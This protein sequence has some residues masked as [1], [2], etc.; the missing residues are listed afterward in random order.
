MRIEDGTP[1]GCERTDGMKHAHPGEKGFCRNWFVLYHN[2]VCS[3]WR[4]ELWSQCQLIKRLHYKEQDTFFAFDS[5]L[6]A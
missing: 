6:W 1:E 2:A 5:R 4:L 3:G